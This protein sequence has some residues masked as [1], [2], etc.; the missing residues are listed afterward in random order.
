[1][2]LTILANL[3]SLRFPKK[4]I[5]FDEDATFGDVIKLM[6]ENR[7]RK[8]LLDGTNQFINDRIIIETIE[9]FNYLFD[10]D[11][12]LEIPTSVVSLEDAKIVLGDLNISDISKTMYEMSQPLIIH[13]D[14]V[15]SPWDVCMALNKS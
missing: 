13:E 5:T 14:R 7:T 4:I 3:T 6:L 11:N 8:I 10:V 2:E 15:I 1:M 9:K 12:F